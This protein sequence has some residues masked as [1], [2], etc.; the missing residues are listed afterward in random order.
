MQELK[1]KQ[2]AELNRLKNEN[3]SQYAIKGSEQEW[4]Q[5]LKGGSKNII[6]VKRY[7]KSTWTFALLTLLFLFITHYFDIVLNV[8][9]LFLCVYVF[10]GEKRPG[11]DTHDNGVDGDFGDE[12]PQKKKKKNRKST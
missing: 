4:G 12:K 7:K 1:A 10:S 3:L 8:T 11:P 9:I 5:A 6:S 2:K